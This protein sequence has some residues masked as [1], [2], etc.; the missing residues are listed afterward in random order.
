MSVPTTNTS[1][2]YLDVRRSSLAAPARG[3]RRQRA[4][5][6]R[7]AGADPWGSVAQDR[8]VERTGTCVECGLVEGTRHR[9]LAHPR[10]PG[11]WALFLVFLLGPAVLVPVLGPQVLIAFMPWF[12]F[13]WWVKTR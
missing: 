7:E 3:G 12:A 1:T 9:C 6:R 4:G 11:M 2:S 5:R 10:P 13:A 8:V